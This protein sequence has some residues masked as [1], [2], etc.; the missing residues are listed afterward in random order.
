MSN[1]TLQEKKVHAEKYCDDIVSNIKKV[2]LMNEIIVQNN[3]LSGV[4]IPLY[5]YAIN[6]IIQKGVKLM[7][8]IHELCGKYIK[9]KIKTYIAENHTETSNLKTLEHFFSSSSSTINYLHK[10]Y[11][12]LNNTST[13]KRNLTFTFKNITE[14]I[15]QDTIN[16]EN[17]LLHCEKINLIGNKENNSSN[18]NNNNNNNDDDA[19]F[20]KID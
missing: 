19:D 2:I 7:N 10:L 3:I 1:Y 12:R 14:I 9:T 18:N 11:A 20:I 8:L 16:I 17:Y 4:S 15:E 13:V 5:E 6:K